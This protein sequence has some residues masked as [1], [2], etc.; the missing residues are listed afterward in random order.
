M[1]F[2]PEGIYPAINDMECYKKN[3]SVLPTPVAHEVSLNILTLP[4]YAD[5]ELEDVDR[6]CELILN[7]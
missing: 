2:L 5:L 3:Y 6:I 1:I 4:M 7:A